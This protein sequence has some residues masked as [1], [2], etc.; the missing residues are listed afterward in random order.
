MKLSEPEKIARVFSALL[1]ADLGYPTMEE[2]VGTNY[3]SA[4]DTC[5]S[6]DYC[7]ANVYMM[8]AFVL[9]GHEA[10]PSDLDEELW[11]AGWDN[12]KA[13]KFYL[14]DHVLEV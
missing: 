2:I 7:D 14:D 11:S 5:A 12:A 4:D 9:T 3:G 1:A 13:N 6:H 8:S 10:D